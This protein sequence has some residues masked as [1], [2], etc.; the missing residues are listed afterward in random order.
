MSLT[1]HLPG[2][3]AA[4]IEAIAT[5][6]GVSVD[7]VVAETL[8]VHLPAEDALEAFIGSGASG[9]GE[10]FDIH[11]ARSELAERKVAEGA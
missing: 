1:V 5:K 4:R 9:R 6:R 3:L 11:A 7:H 10:P 8:S 2:E